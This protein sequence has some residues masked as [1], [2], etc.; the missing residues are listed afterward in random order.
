ME[1]NRSETL[2]LA[3]PS[4]TVCHGAGLRRDRAGANQPCQC[5]LRAIFR[6]CYARFRQCVDKAKQISRVSLEFGSRSQRRITWGRKDEEYIADFTLIARRHLTPAEHQVFRFH[7]LLG[8]DWRLCCR[9]LNI[10]RGVFYHYLYRIEEK[11]G[12]LFRELEPYGLY[13]LDEYF[14]G[15]RREEEEHS[16][17]PTPSEPA[18]QP[19]PLRFP[20]AA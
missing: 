2:V 15:L 9:R 4:C 6:A 5:V 18:A 17:E 16:P 10:E 20:L 1:W 14:H 3:S 13:P 8:A 7:Y 12:R 11:L 19:K